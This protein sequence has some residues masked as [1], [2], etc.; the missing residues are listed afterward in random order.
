MENDE[1]LHDSLA[2]SQFFSVL[3]LLLLP[4]H[5]QR[6]IVTRGMNCSPIAVR[7]NHPGT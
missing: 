6:L 1:E 5:L 7:T 2:V 3:D 4:T